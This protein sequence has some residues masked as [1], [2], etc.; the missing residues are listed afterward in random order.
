ADAV[1]ALEPDHRAARRLALALAGEREAWTEYVVHGEALLRLPAEAG[2][3]ADPDRLRLAVARVYADLLAQPVQSLVHLRALDAR[4][5]LPVD[6]VALYLQA[7]RSAGDPDAHLAALRARV[8]LTGT[9]AARLVLAEHL[10]L[11]DH[12]AEALAEVSGIDPADL[13]HDERQRLALVRDEAA[14]AE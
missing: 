4:G 7:A 9:A 14:D 8:R 10:L 12:P 13:D 2:S 11:T 5:A 3:Q 1:L 6:A